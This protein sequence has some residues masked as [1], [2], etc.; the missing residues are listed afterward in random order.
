MKNYTFLFCLIIFSNVTHG[1]LQFLSDDTLFL[2]MSSALYFENTENTNVDFF[3]G[4]KRI[5][6]SSDEAITGETYC[7][8]PFCFFAHHDVWE[9]P[10]IDWVSP[11][12]DEIDPLEQDYIMLH[13]YNDGPLGAV[14]EYYLY[15]STMEAMDTAV[16]VWSIGNISCEDSNTASLESIKNS[17]DKLSLFP[18]PVNKSFKIMGEW[19]TDKEV[20]YRLIGVQGNIA[21]TGVIEVGQTA[22]NVVDYE[23]GIYF[24]ELSDG[25]NR[26]TLK[27]VVSD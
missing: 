5:C 8:G 9:T 12:F 4:R 25:T 15:S 16:V 20:N 14:M 17:F 7:V 23:D 18:N 13:L 27:V 2:S 3:I 6:T 22:I 26:R 21:A 11:T 19:E 24:L 10:I 1:Q